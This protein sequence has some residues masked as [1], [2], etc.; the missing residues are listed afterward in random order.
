MKQKLENVDWG[1]IENTEN[2]NESYNNFIEHFKKIYDDNFPLKRI[3][4][5]E[6]NIISPWITAGIKKS[7]KQKQRLY[8]KYLKRKSER[9]LQNYKNY[10]KLFETIKKKSKYNYYNTELT[11]YK[12]DI[13]KTW[14]VA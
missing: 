3:E 2:Q 11:K 1:F 4:I 13:K 7:S 9:N 10:K 6:K 12:N 5:K 8:D 14:E